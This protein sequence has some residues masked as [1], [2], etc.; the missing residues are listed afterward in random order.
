[1]LES[2]SNLEALTILKISK[3]EPRKNFKNNS[4]IFIYNI[5]YVVLLYVWKVIKFAWKNY[6]RNI[7]LKS[8]ICIVENFKTFHLDFEHPPIFLFYFWLVKFILHDI[9]RI[10]LY[11]YIKIIHFMVFY[12]FRNCI[13]CSL[14][15]FLFIK[16]LQSPHLM[17]QPFASHP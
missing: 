9:E 3:R 10:V 12:C 17:F 15:N 14:F 8:K 2:V 7:L 13:L 16:S 4:K 5:L 1:M 6:F 11:S